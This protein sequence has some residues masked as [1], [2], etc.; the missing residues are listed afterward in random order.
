MESYLC[1]GTPSHNDQN[2]DKNTHSGYIKLRKTVDKSWNGI[3]KYAKLRDFY[4]VF[5]WIFGRWY[6]SLNWEK[7]SIPLPFS[8]KS[9]VPPVY[10]MT[11]NFTHIPH[12]LKFKWVTGETRLIWCGNCIETGIRLPHSDSL[13]TLNY[14]R[15]VGEIATMTEFIANFYQ[16]RLIKWP[17]N[18]QFPEIFFIN[19]SYSFFK[20]SH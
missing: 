9:T 10:L 15:S 20:P 1:A 7:L 12:S 17:K 3:R 14:C 19:P 6:D 18:R 5:I 2:T 4:V 16:N 8:V 13:K 11:R